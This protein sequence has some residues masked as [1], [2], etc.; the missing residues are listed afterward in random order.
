MK[1]EELPSLWKDP[2]WEGCLLGE[3]GPSGRQTSDAITAWWDGVPPPNLRGVG[4]GLPSDGVESH[5]PSSGARARVSRPMGWS[6]ASQAP[7]R[8]PRS[9]VGWDGEPTPKR[10][11]AGPGLPPDGMEHRLPIYG[12]GP[13]LP[14]DGVEYR[15]PSAGARARVSRCPC[16]LRRNAEASTAAA[17]T[18]IDTFAL[19]LILLRWRRQPRGGQGGSGGVRPPGRKKYGF[20]SLIFLLPY[21]LAPPS[22]GGHV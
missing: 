4:P 7:G 5:I 16:P 1:I 20:T 6:A 17:R 22:L 10:R 2:R 13:G 11:G 8:G 12:A 14:S 9:P 3:S 19:K 21:E 18:K 15:L